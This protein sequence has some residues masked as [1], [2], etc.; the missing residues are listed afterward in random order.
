M[1]YQDHIRQAVVR[2]LAAVLCRGLNWPEKA[3]L[4]GTCNK[5][6]DEGKALQGSAVS[7]A[8]A[9]AR[10]SAFDERARGVFYGMFVCSGGAFLPCV[11]ARARVVLAAQ[12]G[13]QGRTAGR[14][15]N[16]RL[17]FPRPLSHF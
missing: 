12:I 11:R 13:G 6:M 9:G 8:R 16:Q 2:V 4:R 10:S 3:L 7:P 5:C 17:T 15:E 14:R 1:R